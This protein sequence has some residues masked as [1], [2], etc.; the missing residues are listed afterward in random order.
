MRGGKEKKK[1]KQTKLLSHP[2]ML[3]RAMKKRQKK[4]S[5]I[6]KVEKEKGNG[7]GARKYLLRR[8]IKVPAEGR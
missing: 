6:L 4:E 7:T 2:Q 8:G 5:H 3:V 1:K